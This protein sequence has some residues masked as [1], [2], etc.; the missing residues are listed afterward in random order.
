MA[1][2]TVYTTAIVLGG[3]IVLIFIIL[4]IPGIFLIGIYNLL[5]KIKN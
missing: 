2:S 3:I 5:L 1:M 4:W